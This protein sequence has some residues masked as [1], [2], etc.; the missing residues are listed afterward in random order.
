MG[1]VIILNDGIVMYSLQRF[2]K[3]KEHLGRQEFPWMGRILHNL[4]RR[5]LSLLIDQK[6]FI[7]Y[8]DISLIEKVIVYASC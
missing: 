3:V 8:Y 1:F 6:H 5:V 4:C 7:S 2:S